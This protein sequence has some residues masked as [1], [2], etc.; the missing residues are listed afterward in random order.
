MSVACPYGFSTKQLS[1]LNLS[2]P[3]SSNTFNFS[4]AKFI[5]GNLSLIRCDQA[6]F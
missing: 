3:P 5:V 1:S 2:I 6:Q 4:S